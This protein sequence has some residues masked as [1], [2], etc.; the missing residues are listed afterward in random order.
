MGPKRRTARYYARKAG[1][2][3]AGR[4]D[5]RAASYANYNTFNQDTFNEVSRRDTNA[6]YVSDDSIYKTRAPSVFNL[7]KRRAYLQKKAEMTPEQWKI[8]MR[9]ERL[10]RKIYDVDRR[11]V[12]M[13]TKID[14]DEKVVQAR[15]T[16]LDHVLTNVKNNK[17][18]LAKYMS[19]AKAR[20]YNIWDKR[21]RTNA[22][23][24]ADNEVFTDNP[25]YFP[26]G[27]G[28]YGSHG[29]AGTNPSVAGNA[30]QVD[31]TGT[32]AENPGGFIGAGLVNVPPPTAPGYN[33]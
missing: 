24:L 16:L 8:L 11:I 22:N 3:R 20:P 5:S 13:A 7:I 12:G 6:P 32:N 29:S 9:N 17:G 23:Y 25:Y 14:Y 27:G 19:M 4:G 18:D 28:G 10:R 21:L 1:R 26:F 2:R 30:M 33:V 31:T 15:R